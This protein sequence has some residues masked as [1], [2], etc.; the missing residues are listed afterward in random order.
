MNPNPDVQ[1]VPETASRP[2]SAPLAGCRI[3]IPSNLAVRGWPMEAG[4]RALEGYV[5]TEDAFVVEQLRLQGAELTE[6][7]SVAELGFGLDG[8]TAG[9][10]VREE[11]DASLVADAFGECRLLAMANGLAGFKPT[12]GLVSRRGLAGLI[13]S[14]E[15]MSVTARDLSRL[16]QIVGAIAVTDDLDPSMRQE[17]PPGSV[18]GGPVSTAFR[19]I[20]VVQEA[21]ALLSETE[22]NRFRR[23]MERAAARGLDVREI[24]IP[25]FSLIRK[26]HQVI[27]AVEASSSTGRYDGVRFGHRATG[28]SNWNDMY[29]Q[30]RA[31]SFGTRLKSFLFQGACFQF[32]EFEAHQD[33]GRIRRRLLEAVESLFR[34]VDVLALPVRRPAADPVRARTVRQVYDAFEMTLPA[35]LLGLPA[36]VFPGPEK[37]AADDPGLQWVAPALR[38][39]DL[40]S[41]GAFLAG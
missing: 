8:G 20:G 30:T 1:P 25:E 23:Q 32:K 28:A 6:G 33:A 38:D 16:S 11:A 4:S 17:V 40:L 9:M 18:S 19:T 27:G 5:A 24:S 7:L 35:S 31:E 22:Q 14:M 13:P 21:V 26:A 29:L 12:Q 34:Q 39:G 3:A 15:C 10:A 36:A 37:P 2:A 41:F